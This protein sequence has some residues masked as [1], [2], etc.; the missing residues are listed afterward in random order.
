MTEVRL[1]RSEGRILGIEIRGHAGFA[2]KGE[3][4]VC[5]GLSTVIQ[6]LDI[7]LSEVLGRTDIEVQKNPEKAFMSVFLDGPEEKCATVLMQTAA[8][9]LWAIAESHPSHVRITEVDHDEVF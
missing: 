1:F 3:D 9:S 8:R 5:A 4:I 7:G 6:A 2:E